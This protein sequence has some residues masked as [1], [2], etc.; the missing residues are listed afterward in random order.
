MAEE[1][2]ASIDELTRSLVEALNACGV[3]YMLIGG[4]P[5]MHYGRPRSTVDC[6]VVISIR[7]E[8]IAKFC[9]CLDKHGFEIDEKD[10]QMA[11][12]EKSHFNAYRKNE[13]GFR[14]D[15]SWKK[16]SLDEYGFKRAKKLEIFGVTAIVE[17][18]EDIIIAKLVYGSQ[19]DF[20]DAAAIL[21]R[22]KNLDTAYLQRRAVQENVAKQLEKLF[23]FVEK[24]K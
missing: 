13:Y 24:W 23:K 15:F 5:A 2:I 21:K 3:Q 7:E 22:Q 1:T 18:P 17:A 9:I 10:V 6:D 8:E 4:V 16:T 11:F 20:E 14:V 12:R 19:Q